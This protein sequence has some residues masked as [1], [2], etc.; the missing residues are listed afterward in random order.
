MNHYRCLPQASLLKSILSF[1]TIFWEIY[2]YP[3]EF[4]S[5]FFSETE[6]LNAILPKLSSSGTGRARTVSVHR[7]TGFFAAVP[8]HVTSST[9]CQVRTIEKRPGLVE[10]VRA[11]TQ[12]RHCYLSPT[13]CHDSPD[14]RVLGLADRDALWGCAVWCLMMEESMRKGMRLS[15]QPLSGLNEEKPSKALLINGE[16]TSSGR[17]QEFI[18]S[19]FWVS[20]KKIRH[21]HKKR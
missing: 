13:L 8:H 11:K 2:F 16:V 18:S 12:R 3:S 14:P 5:L 4:S 7:C 1:R 15:L 20:P 19:K 17:K 21:L 9:R 10:S 6:I